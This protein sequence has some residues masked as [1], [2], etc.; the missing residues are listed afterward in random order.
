MVFFGSSFVSVNFFRYHPVPPSTNPVA[1]API[2][3][4]SKGPLVLPVICGSSFSFL[5]YNLPPI[6]HAPQLTLLSDSL[7][8]IHYSLFIIHA[9]PI[10]HSPFTIHPL[11]LSHSSTSS[12]TTLLI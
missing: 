3:F 4:V 12:P 7:F 5:L 9:L 2:L 8:T 10:D 6:K 11:S 1:L